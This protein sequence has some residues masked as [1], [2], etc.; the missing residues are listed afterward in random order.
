MN[1]SIAMMLINPSIR[2]VLVSY[3]P[4]GTNPDLPLTPTRGIRSMI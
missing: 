4:H 2:A 1:Y 3:E